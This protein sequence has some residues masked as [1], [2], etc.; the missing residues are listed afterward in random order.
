M[1]PG[2]TVE[3]RGQALPVEPSADTGRIRE[4]ADELQPCPHCGCRAGYNHDCEECCR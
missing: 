1:E 4:P 2:E 3:L